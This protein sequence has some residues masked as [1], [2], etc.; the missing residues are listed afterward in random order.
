MIR[1]WILA[2][3]VVGAFSGVSC[4][5][6]PS[7]PMDSPALQAPP[8]PIVSPPAASGQQCDAP[9]LAYLIGHPKSDIPVPIDPSRRRVYC[10]SCFVTE[11]YR[12]DRTDIVYD[13][14]TG[15]VTAV[16]CG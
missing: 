1:R 8:P 15:L 12:P 3:V 4:A 14:Q 2:M 6:T 7:L 9:S 5:Q 10:S 13:D 11:D 16:K